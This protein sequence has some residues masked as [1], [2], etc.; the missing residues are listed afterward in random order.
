MTSVLRN[1]D[2]LFNMA[3][4][5]SHMDS[6]RQPHE[7][8]DVNAR[9]QLTILDAC[10]AVN[11][12]VRIVHAST[13]Q[14]YGRAESL[15]VT[16]MHR[17]RPPDV[18]GINKLAG[19]LYYSLYEHVYGIRTTVLRL[20]NVFGPGMRIRDGRQTFMGLWFRALLQNT[21]FDVWGGDQVRDLLFVD[22]AVDAFCAAACNTSAVRL[23]NVGGIESLSLHALAKMMIAVNGG[24]RYEVIAYPDDR[25]PIEIGDFVTDSRMLTATLGWVP[26]TTIAEGVRQTLDYYAANMARYTP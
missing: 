21:S 16:E 4:L 17:I 3:A 20:T 5:I 19:E 6:M 7:D 8:L 1:Q 22:D 10:R 23:F 13:R 12:T 14:V 26:R 11:P 24:G 25:R 9:A 2:Y 15:P 18:N